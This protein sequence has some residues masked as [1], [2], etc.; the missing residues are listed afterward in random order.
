[1][2]FLPPMHELLSY[3]VAVSHLKIKID[4]KKVK[5]AIGYYY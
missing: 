1:M 4:R 3:A 2:H 5:F